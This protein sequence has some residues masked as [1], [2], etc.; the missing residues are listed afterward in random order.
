MF[1]EYEKVGGGQRN[2]TDSTIKVQND[3]S[4][5]GLTVPPEA[6]PTFWSWM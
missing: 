5:N 1:Y 3:R 4:G 6:G 2:L